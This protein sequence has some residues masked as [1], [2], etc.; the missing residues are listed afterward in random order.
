LRDSCIDEERL[1]NLANN[2]SILEISKIENIPYSTIW[3]NLK[4]YNILISRSSKYNYPLFDTFTPESCYWAGFIAA[5]GNVFVGK[6]DYRISLHLNIKDINHLE[7]FKECVGTTNKISIGHRDCYIQVCSKQMF[8]SLNNNFN[9]VPRKSL[10]L[11]PPQ[12]PENLLSHY[13]RGYFDGDGHIGCYGGTCN[14]NIVSGSRDIIYWISN[15]LQYF[16]LI[17]KDHIYGKKSFRIDVKNKNSIKIFDWL[18]KDSTIKLDRKYKKY[19]EYK[20]IDLDYKAISNEYLGGDSLEDLSK[21]YNISKWVLLGKFKKLGVRKTT[22]RVLNN[23]FIDINE[24]SC[25][26]AGF[27]SA[28]GWVDKYHLSIELSHK[29]RTHLFKIKDF[30]NSNAEIKQRDRKSFGKITKSC[31]IQFN[32]LDLVQSLLINFNIVRN[33]TLILKPPNLPTNMI[34]HF[35]RGYV[36]GD[37][38]VGW[39]KV[40][41]LFICSGSKDFL[42]WVYNQIKS[43]KCGN[44]SITKRNSN[45][46]CVE[47]K[48]KYTINI[49]NW[50]YGNSNIYLDRKYN[51]FLEYNDKLSI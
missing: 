50:L 5:D 36:D 43:I 26:W 32:S 34:R 23:N 42:T 4:K 9:I 27:I 48:G 29:D 33:K 24:Y 44:P 30:L 1:R 22:K 28:D 46:Y 15:K 7:K 40:P 18:Y 37:G 13:I 16:G 17:N 31:V 47:F 39:N 8:F 38:S 41:R 51:R 25:Y 45:T 2:H 35:I 6:G 11:Q 20:N 12:I 49:L 21:K 10:T 14:F 3:Y 19:C